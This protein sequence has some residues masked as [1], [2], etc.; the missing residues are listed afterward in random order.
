[1]ETAMAETMTDRRIAP[2]VD[3]RVS[4]K[5]GIEMTIRNTRPNDV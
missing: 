4:L 1:M 5:D 2:R 3:K